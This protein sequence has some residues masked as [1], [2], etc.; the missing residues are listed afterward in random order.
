M[1]TDQFQKEQIEEASILTA[2]YLQ[3][4]QGKHKQF[5]FL[6]CWEHRKIAKYYL[7]GLKKIVH[8]FKILS[9]TQDKLIKILKEAG[10]LDIINYTYAKQL[11]LC[12]KFYKE[13][14][15]IVKDMLSEYREYICS[16]HIIDTFILPRL[17]TEYEL[18]DY[19]T[20]PGVWIF[21]KPN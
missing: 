7:K 16:G 8:D 19:R 17:R 11:H 20:L 5:E 2:L 13:E 1:E 6:R 3:A 4:L 18:V 21:K 10:K 12:V 15:R 14:C 9:K